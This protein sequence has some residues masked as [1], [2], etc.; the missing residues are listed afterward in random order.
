MNWFDCVDACHDLSKDGKEDWHIACIE[1][2]HEV[3]LAQ[4]AL[5]DIHRMLVTANGLHDIPVGVENGAWIG[6]SAKK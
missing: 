3:D 6:F 5:E 1:N 2:E 4:H